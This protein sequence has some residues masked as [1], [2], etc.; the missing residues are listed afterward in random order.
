MSQ[1]SYF[2]S[3]RIQISHCNLNISLWQWMSQRSDAHIF[4]LIHY[5]VI[6]S[7]PTRIF[8][9]L[10]TLVLNYIDLLIMFV[11]IG[12]STRFKQFNDRLDLVKGLV[13][14]MT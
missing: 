7:I 6:L 4:T 11:S 9:I 1:A 13:L 5:N 2:D 10:A 3:N 12:L 14:T 8:P